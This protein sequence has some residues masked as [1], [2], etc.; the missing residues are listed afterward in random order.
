[1]TY[2]VTPFDCSTA[3]GLADALASTAPP[4]S[5][6][7]SS[8]PTKES[9]LQQLSSLVRDKAGPPHS[10]AD[11]FILRVCAPFAFLRLLPDI[12]RVVLS[13]VLEVAE[14][15]ALRRI[16]YDYSNWENPDSILES[17]PREIRHLGR[18]TVK[19]QLERSKW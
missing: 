10:E 7:A 15:H 8:Y 17:Y 9:Y 18:G 12:R 2:C 19:Y 5:P 13:Y 3:A 4:P 11:A 16:E 6:L 14:G 1:M